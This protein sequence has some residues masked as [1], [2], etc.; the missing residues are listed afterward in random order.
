LK[1]YAAFGVPLVHLEA[2]SVY[3]EAAKEMR[4][5]LAQKAISLVS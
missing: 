4:R 1:L 2:E 5:V 3:G